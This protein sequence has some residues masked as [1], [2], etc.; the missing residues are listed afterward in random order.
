MSADD[1]PIDWL[2]DGDPVIRWQT[3][4]DLLHVPESVWRKEQSKTIET[5]WGA[6]Y[7]A[8]MKPDLTWPAG[9]WTGSVWTLLVIIDC[10]LPADHPP[11][12]AAAQA[13]LDKHLTAERARD[14]KWLR[15]RM[16]LCHLGFW[17]RIGSYFLGNDPRLADLASTV[18]AVQM[19]D[20]GFNCRIRNAPHTRHSSFHTTF[21]VL[22]G[23]AASA[24]AG[25][26]TAKAFRAVEAPALEFM[27][28]HRM[29]R[30]DRTGDVI[31]GR[32]THLCHP[33]HWH[34]TVLR[35][36]DYLRH[37][38]Q[39]ADSR[40]DDA[41]ALLASRRKRN[42]RW[43]VE[44]RIPGIEHFDMEKPGGESRWNTLRALRVLKARKS[45]STQ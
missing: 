20:G 44:K 29:Y 27:L 6:K 21:N 19:A 12:R 35:G 24:A 23:L 17:L 37:T 16:D 34:Y 43:P 18:V 11:L 42:G 2:M 32:F 39:I 13:F 45:V 36:L 25:V 40:L 7:L 8:A 4:R 33:S 14:P 22:E 30:S 5:G 26:I 9:R 41:V 38:P 15:T 31:D 28:A 1:A 10:G 3:Q